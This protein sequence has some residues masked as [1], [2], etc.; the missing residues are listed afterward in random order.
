MPDITTTSNYTTALPDYRGEN[1]VSTQ[2]GMCY[3]DGTI[4][5]GSDNSI[6]FHKLV[7]GNT[8]T[9]TTADWRSILRRRGTAASVDL[10]EYIAAHQLI[11]RTIVWAVTEAEDVA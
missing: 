11:K 6:A 1:V 7:E 9:A 5:W 8:T 2:F 3:P 4:R 10:E